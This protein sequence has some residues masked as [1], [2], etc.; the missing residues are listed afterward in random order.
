MVF[1]D[2]DY[3]T[4]VL[5]LIDTIKEADISDCDKGIVA[6]FEHEGTVSFLWEKYIP[7]EYEAGNE[8]E[9]AKDNWVIDKSTIVCN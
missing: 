4:R 8:I 1:W 5:E 9:V 6:I 2:E 3:D 7:N